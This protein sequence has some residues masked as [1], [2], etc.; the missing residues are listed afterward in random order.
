MRLTFMRD[1]PMWMRVYECRAGGAVSLLKDLRPIR[2]D[3]EVCEYLDVG[4]DVPAHAARIYVFS[5]PA[6]IA[7]AA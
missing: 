1:V 4:A 5:R 6:P 2:K 3:T 7:K